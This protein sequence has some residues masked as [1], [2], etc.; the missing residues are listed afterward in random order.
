MKVEMDST[1]QIIV[2]PIL[3]GYRTDIDIIK[4]VYV[5]ICECTTKSL[6]NRQYL[7]YILQ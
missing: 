7:Y 4:L 6:A 3:Y 2:L 5:A 1:I